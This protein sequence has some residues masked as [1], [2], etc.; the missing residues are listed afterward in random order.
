MRAE[1]FSPAA[2]R[3]PIGRR[4]KALGSRYEG[5]LRGL[6]ATRFLTPPTLLIAE[7]SLMPYNEQSP[8][9][10]NKHHLTFREACQQLL[11]RRI[12]LPGRLLNVI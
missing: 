9:Q 8:L 2:R 4:A 11:K 7:G 5:H 12:K 3:T 6:S 10:S 1:G